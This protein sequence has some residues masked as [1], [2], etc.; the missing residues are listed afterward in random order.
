MA[1]MLTNEDSSPNEP[2]QSR[3]YSVWS[4]LRAMKFLGQVQQEMRSLKAK[5][6]RL[7]LALVVSV[8]ILGGT[9]IA[10]AVMLAVTYSQ[11]QDLRRQLQPAQPQPEL[12]S[13]VPQV[14]GVKLSSPAS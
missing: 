13:S 7:Q 3:Q 14:E 8:L 9:T 11:L 4:D 1:F 6:S 5:S 12:Q 2:Q 10:M